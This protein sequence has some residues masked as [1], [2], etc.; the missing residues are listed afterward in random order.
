MAN[1]K[2]YPKRIIQNIHKINQ[3]MQKNDK[4]WSLVTKVLGGHKKT[5]EKILQSEV[6]L[7]T[8]SIADS[9]VSNLK[10]IKKIKSK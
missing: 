6:I 5:L 10:V 9:R 3:Y 1:L 7:E 2:I 8:H 4:E